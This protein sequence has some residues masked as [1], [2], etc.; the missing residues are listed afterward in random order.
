M[1]IENIVEKELEKRDNSKRLNQLIGF[2]NFFR[3]KYHDFINLPDGDGIVNFSKND[4]IYSIKQLSDILCDFISLAGYL[5][6]REEFEHNEEVRKT[7]IEEANKKFEDLQKFYT[8]K[9]ET[10]VKQLNQLNHEIN[11]LKNSKNLKT[12]KLAV[13]KQLI[14][15]LPE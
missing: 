15:D 13:I 9:F 5:Y 7:T 11:C 8:S 1:D 14:E 2:I 10:Q 12:K 3:L 6:Y 4:F